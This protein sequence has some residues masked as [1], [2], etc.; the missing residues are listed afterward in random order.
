MNRIVEPGNSLASGVGVTEALTRFSVQPAILA[1][2]SGTRLWPLS[3][4]RNPKQLIDLIGDESL[5]EATLR[6]LDDAFAVAAHHTS[7]VDPLATATPLVVCCEDLRL[8]TRERLEQCSRP[9]RMMLEPV[10][11]NTAPALTVAALAARAAAAAGDDPIIVALPADHLIADHA[12]FGVALSE[13]LGHAACGAIVTLGVPP[14]RAA[15]G[16]GY[17]RTGTALGTRGARAI[18]RFVEKPDAE[19]AERYVASGEYWWNSGMFVVRASVWLAA[20]ALCRPVIA[21]AC[22]DAFEHA[23]VDGDGALHLARDAFAAC[24]SDSI[25]YAVMERVATDARLVG[26]TVPLV[27][28][29]SDVGA[30]DSVWDASSKDASGNVARGRVMFDGSTNSFAHSEGRLVACVGVSGVVVVE[31]ADAVLVAAKDRV[32]DVKA[33]VGRLKAERRAE[34]HEHRKVGRPWGFYDSLEHG[35][36]FQVKRIVVKPGGR[37]SLQMHHHRAEHWIVVRGTALV[38]R[39][40][41]SFLVSENQS[42]FI[43]LGVTHRLEN[44]GKTPLEMIEVQSGCYL[45]E[46]DIVRFDDQY[47]RLQVSGDAGKGASH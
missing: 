16:Y 7:S 5:L 3:R 29:W 39:G 18:E 33:I 2:G 6:R 28:G 42:T 1:G 47:G 27:A 15:T 45:G 21:A 40:E 12:A 4:E 31:T 35:E 25:D 30:W 13:A 32:Q 20:I 17:I 24:P 19:L 10:P 44:P 36:R 11:R 26:V 8:Q 41:E 23:T 37:L 9:V 38:T 46:D 14:Q 22:A 34:A 43:P